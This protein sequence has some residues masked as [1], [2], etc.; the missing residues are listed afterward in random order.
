M[1][2]LLLVWVPVLLLAGALNFWACL[3][4]FSLVKLLL[5]GACWALAMKL[6]YNYLR[7]DY[8]ED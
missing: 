4:G 6:I 1:K 2:F 7:G 8:E 3:Q 5:G